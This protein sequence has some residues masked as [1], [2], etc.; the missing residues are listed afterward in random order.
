MGIHGT[1]LSWFRSYLSGR[2]QKVV[3][4]GSESNINT[5]TCGVPQGSVLGPL[6]FLIYINDLVENLECDSFLF[7]DD[8]SLFKR[9]HN[10]SA[11]AADSLNRDLEKINLWCQKWLL[12]INVGKTKDI[13]FSRKRQPSN[14]P[15]LYFNNLVIE[16]V[17]SHKQLGIVLDAKLDWS[18]HIEDI[19]SRSL[20]RINAWKGLQFKLSRKHLETCLTLFVLPILDY[21][22]I[23]YDNCSEA[24]KEDL[25]AVHIAAARVVTGAKRYT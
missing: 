8:T 25:E 9:L 2:R 7:A 3:L 10:D 20:Q 14:L 11:S 12:H 16:T 18:E 13:L 21:G 22:D 6:L 17:S 1:M 4:G 23:L 5:L 19:C 15:P 24:N